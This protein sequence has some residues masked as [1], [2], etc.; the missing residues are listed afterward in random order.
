MTIERVMM[1]IVIDIINSCRYFVGREQKKM[2]GNNSEIIIINFDLIQ[3]DAKNIILGNAFAN[4]LNY[5][6]LSS[7]KAQ[8]ISVY[9]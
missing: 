8:N 1:I 2:E 6:V 7:I 4:S 9:E 3:T 5:S